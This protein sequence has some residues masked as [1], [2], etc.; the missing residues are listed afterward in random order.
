M[1]KGNVTLFRKFKERLGDGEINLTTAVFKIIL[2]NDTTA[3]LPGGGAQATDPRYGA[4]GSQDLSTN[5]CANGGG[6]T[7]GGTAIDGSD[8]WAVNGDDCEYTADNPT[9]LSSFS[10][11]PTNIR[12]GV[13]YV[14]NGGTTDY[15]MG[16]VQIY[17][18]TTDVD[19]TVGDVI[20]KWDGGA[21]NGVV[22]SI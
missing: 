16:Y 9:F 14:D 3:A 18:G 20:V 8:P 17:D 1:A 22:F 11:D 15:G 6:Y 19:L 4:G 10:G 5:E 12:Y 13:V 7:T 2:T 21:L